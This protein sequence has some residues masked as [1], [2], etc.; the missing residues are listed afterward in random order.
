MGE[1][2]AFPPMNVLFAEPDKMFRL[3]AAVLDP[4]QADERFL[5][6]FFLT[7]SADPGRLLLAW[8]H[9][10]RLPRDMAVHVAEDAADFAASLPA[11]DVVV[12]EKQSLDAA[13]LRR[14]GR[15]KLVQV[16]GR[17]AAAVDVAA[18]EAQGVAVRTLDRHTNRLVAEHAVMMMLALLHRLD[19]S[20]AAMSAPS[21][22]SP[23]AWAYNWPAVTGVR[24]LAGRTVGLIGMGE[25]AQ[26][27]ALHLRAF[28]AK[29]I[30][31][32]RHRDT[33]VEAEL[34][35]AYAD[36]PALLAR[37]DI[38][39]IHVP[40]GTDTR[41]L[42]D[43]GAL[44]RMKAG[45]Y[46]VNTAR[47]AIVDEAALLAAL[48]SGHVAGAALDVFTVEPLPLDHGFHGLPNVILTPHLAA[49]SR[50]AAWLD[51][52]IGPVI[53]AVCGARPAAAA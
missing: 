4:A 18:A 15:L 8:A 12:L 47:G 53:D 49:G 39:S 11:A 22:L 36:L 13:L 14:A 27:V 17:D 48:R 45:A 34:G 10:R 46:L 7:E 28:G 41:H 25:V 33:R 42:L 23:G 50:D 20:R 2:G 3:I 32:R 29:V 43:A 35:M 1:I 16:F 30:Y 31:T 40:G 5:S 6:E 44:G 24:G 9:A 51:L 19:A 37:S 52:E 26:L 21:R 38:V